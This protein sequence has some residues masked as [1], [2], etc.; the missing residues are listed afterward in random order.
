MIQI[1]IK[2]KTE[3]RKELGNNMNVVSLPKRTKAK[4]QQLIVDLFWDYQRLTQSGQ[5][6]L[7]KLANL[8]GVPTEKEMEEMTEA[9]NHID[10]IPCDV[11]PRNG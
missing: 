5:A 9:D 4:T 8:W 7:D 11:E 1:Y 10:S 6:S 3:R 2:R